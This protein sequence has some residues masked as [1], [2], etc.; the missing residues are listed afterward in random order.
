[1]ETHNLQSILPASPDGPP[2]VVLHDAAKFK[3]IVL[4]L[5]PG[6]TI[7]PCKMLSHVIF[8]VVEG[9]IQVTVD[10]AP[11]TLRSGECLITEPA[12]LS[13]HSAGGARVMGTQIH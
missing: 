2:R 7:P 3:V 5:P 10:G 9:E 11:R 13:M 12:T 1:M 4:V 8:T 6:G